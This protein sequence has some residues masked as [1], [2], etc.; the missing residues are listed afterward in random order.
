M[1][2][3]PAVFC[4]HIPLLA[5]PALNLCR[6]CGTAYVFMRCWQ[7]ATSTRGA[8]SVNSTAF[9]SSALSETLA[10]S[11]SGCSNQAKQDAMMQIDNAH[12]A[13]WKQ[14]VGRLWQVRVDVSV[15]ALFHV[16][17]AVHP[18]FVTRT[19]I[20]TRS[21]FLSHRERR[22]SL[23]RV[24]LFMKIHQCLRR[25]LIALSFCSRPKLSMP[26]Q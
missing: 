19:R 14:A 6:C 15:A 18:A 13:W 24:L 5:R 4:D 21:L 22:L 3:T 2:A 10:R 25:L 1:W 16:M 23:R 9:G 8:V 11:P 17:P 12:H 26:Q 20:A 7:G